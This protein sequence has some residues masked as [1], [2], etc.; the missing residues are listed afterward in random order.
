MR[1]WEFVVS[2][3]RI[4]GDTLR[5]PVRI[6]MLRFP[7]IRIAS[8]LITIIVSHLGI[9][10]SSVSVIKDETR[11]ALSATGSSS[12]PSFV[13]WCLILASKPS[14]RSVSPATAKKIMA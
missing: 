1:T 4:L 5:S 6:Y 12:A 2:L 10:S 9:H 13:F 11:R 3:P 14:S 7:T 8:L